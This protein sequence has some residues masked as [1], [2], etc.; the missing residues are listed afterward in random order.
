M[1]MPLGLSCGHI[2]CTE[3]VFHAIGI[4]NWARPLKQVRRAFPFIISAVHIPFCDQNHAHGASCW[5]DFHLSRIA[6]NE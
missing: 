5:P 3:C 6:H 1:W 4:R 2:F